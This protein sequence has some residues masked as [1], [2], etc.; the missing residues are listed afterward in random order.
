MRVGV[1][2]G[3]S[4][5]LRGLEPSARLAR[6]ASSRSMTLELDLYCGSSLVA[7]NDLKS[8]EADSFRCAAMLTS[9]LPTRALPTGRSVSWVSS[10][11]AMQSSVRLRHMLSALLRSRRSMPLKVPAKDAVLGETLCALE[12]PAMAASASASDTV[13]SRDL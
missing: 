9:L 2:C 8:C 3:D 1:S 7:R 5:R 4:R 13:A 12:P 6:R 10:D 11:N